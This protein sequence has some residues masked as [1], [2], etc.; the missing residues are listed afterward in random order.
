VVEPLTDLGRGGGTE[1]R[2]AAGHRDRDYSRKD[3][4]EAVSLGEE[5]DGELGRKKA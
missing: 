5:L 2:G 1:G 3:L 4:L